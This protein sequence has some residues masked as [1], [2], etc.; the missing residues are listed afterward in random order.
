MTIRGRLGV[1]V[2]G[3][4]ALGFGW[5]AVPAAAKT[6]CEHGYS[7]LIA[8]NL[9]ADLWQEFDCSGLYGKCSTGY[10][11]DTLFIWW[12]SPNPAK[13]GEDSTCDEAK[14]L[15]GTLTAHLNFR[16]RENKPCPYRGWYEG[17]F[18]LT[19]P[20]T[21]V[22]FATG[23]IR[24]TVGVGTH[25]KPCVG[26]ACD[27]V[28]ETCYDVARDPETGLWRLASE[29]TYT[30][31]V[32]EGPWAGCSLHVS[33]EGDFF[34]PDSGSGSPQMPPGWKFTGH[35]DGVLECDCVP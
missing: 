27:S 20:D 10:G 5:T 21:G 11:S 26:A 9:V 19:D 22:V 28:C 29:G 6:V 18:E 16:L 3:M 32:I 4:M 14:R 30:G 13:C 8:S 12:L 25:Q 15:N 35:A 1:V 31:T 33:Y 2:A 24:G 34:A 7:K 23:D 17:P